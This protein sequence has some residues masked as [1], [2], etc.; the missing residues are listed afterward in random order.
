VA[1]GEV[2]T[3]RLDQQLVHASGR[4]VPVE[5]SVTPL[6]TG[7]GPDVTGDPSR[8][9]LVAH[10]QDLTERTGSGDELRRFETGHTPPS[11]TAA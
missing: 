5:L 4:T 1:S 7:G 8:R 3:L 2:A 6:T 10:F 9:G 11:Q